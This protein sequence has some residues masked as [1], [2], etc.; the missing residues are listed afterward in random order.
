MPQNVKITIIQTDIK[1]ASP[2]DNIISAEAMLDGAR[3]SDLYVLPEMWATG[4]ARRRRKPA[5][6]CPWNG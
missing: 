3:Q 5:P 2:K 4:S 1:W 6:P